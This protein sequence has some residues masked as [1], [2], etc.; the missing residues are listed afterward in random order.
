M[1]TNTKEI[2]FEDF[3]EDELLVLHKYKARTTANFDKKLAMDTELVV[4]FVKIGRAHV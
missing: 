4:Q 1:K 3:I 2:G